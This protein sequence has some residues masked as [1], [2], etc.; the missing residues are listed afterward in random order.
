MDLELA[1]FAR[2]ADVARGGD[3]HVHRALTDLAVEELPVQVNLD[4]VT[5]WELQPEDVGEHVFDLRGGT[6]EHTLYEGE[7]KLDVHGLEQPRAFITHVLPFQNLEIHE[8]GPHDFT[9]H[10]RGTGARHTI[11]LQ[12]VRN[13][14]GPA[15]D[16]AEPDTGG[17]LLA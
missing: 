16:G 3:L 9:L 7:F 12:V 2:A 14:Q 8:L 11:P 4:L 6:A 15:P 13:Q 10:A 5:R 1:T 17:E